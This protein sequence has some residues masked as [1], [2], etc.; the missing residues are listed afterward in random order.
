MQLFQ[1]SWNYERMQA[2]VFAFTMKPVIEMLY[3]SCLC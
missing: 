1:V 2:L 3:R